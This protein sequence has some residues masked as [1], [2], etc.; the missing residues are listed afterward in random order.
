MLVSCI[1]KRLLERKILGPGLIVDKKLTDLVR[2]RSSCLAIPTYWATVAKGLCEAENC[3]GITSWN[4]RA[5][6]TW[7]ASTSLSINN[8]PICTMALLN[9]IHSG[10]PIAHSLVICAVVFVERSLIPTVCRFVQYVN[11]NSTVGYFCRKTGG[12]RF[13]HYRGIPFQLKS[14]RDLQAKCLMKM[15]KASR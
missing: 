8:C 5:Y 12:D 3:D 4:V 2:Q 14:Y 9:T 10:D 15:L 13:P 11:K 1:P 6:P 7:G